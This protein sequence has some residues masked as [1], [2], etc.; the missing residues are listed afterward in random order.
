MSYSPCART[1]VQVSGVV[2][3]A[4]TIMGAAPSRTEV[5]I[6]DRLMAT[7]QTTWA[8]VDVT[9][10]PAGNYTV[11]VVAR[12][13]LTQYE[14]SSTKFDDP[15]TPF[16]ATAYVA[17]TTAPPSPSR[18]VNTTSK[19]VG[20]LLPS[21]LQFEYA[22]AVLAEDGVWYAFYCSPG[23]ADAQSFIRLTTRCCC[24]WGA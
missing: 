2:R 22:P 1:R 15:V 20:F 21:P 7:S 18:A 24:R 19:A 16:D 11:K 8:I 9:S 6:N 17:I 4:W 3:V 14:L 23:Q 5:Y 13:A 12:G 10:L